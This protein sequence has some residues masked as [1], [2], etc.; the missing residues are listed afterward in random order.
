M[1]NLMLLSVVLFVV[2]CTPKPAEPV[3]LLADSLAVDTP[4]VEEVKIDTT[5]T[6]DSLKK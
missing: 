5:L 3:N 1:K 6:T 4:K 2:S